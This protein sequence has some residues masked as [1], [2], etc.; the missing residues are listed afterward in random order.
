M[1][2]ERVKAF[3]REVRRRRE[4]LGLTIDMLGEKADLTPI[5]LGEV[6]APTRRKRGPSLEVAFRIADGLGVE[7]PELLGYKG[8]SG[9]GLEAG[10][11]VST[12]RPRMR[13]AVLA[14]LAG[15]AKQGA[16]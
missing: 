16:P 10:R 13:R 3:G 9:A 2:S 5:Y 8:L 4:A 7:L 12:F 6:E 14:L 11:L 1:S 15:I